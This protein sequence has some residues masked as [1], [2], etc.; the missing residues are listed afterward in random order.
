MIFYFIPLFTYIA[1]ITLINLYKYSRISTF[2]WRKFLVIVLTTPVASIFFPDL[3]SD[4]NESNR[5][6][7]LAHKKIEKLRKIAY[8]K[9]EAKK[10]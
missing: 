8:S 2:S 4:L 10:C 7:K 9:P 5:Q 3:I 1:I 6:L